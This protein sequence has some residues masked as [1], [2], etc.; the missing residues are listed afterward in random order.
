MEAPSYHDEEEGSTSTRNG[1]AGSEFAVY[2]TTPE[3]K[4]TELPSGTTVLG[5]GNQKLGITDRRVSRKHA[6][7]TVSKETNTVTLMSVRQGPTTKII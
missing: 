6:E 7:V 5:R 1:S 4:T 3:G 2:M